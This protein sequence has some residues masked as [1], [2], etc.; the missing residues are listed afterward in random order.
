MSL[1]RRHRGGGAVESRATW[2]VP[3]WLTA[4]FGQTTAAGKP[5]SVENVMKSNAFAACRRVLVSEI[6]QLP[7]HAYRKSGST[8][9][10]VSPSPSI[11]STPAGGVSRRNWTAQ[12][13]DSLVRAGNAYCLIRRDSAGVVVGAE[14][15]AP[16]VVTWSHVDN[17]LRPFVGGVERDLFPNGDLLHIPASA[18]ITAGSPVA[19]SP[20]EAS[21]ES[22]GLGLAAESYVAEWFGS[23]GHPSSILFVD[24]EIT[25]QQAEQIK[26]RYV[27]STQGRRPAVFGAGIT[28]ESTQTPPDETMLNLARFVVE[29]ACRTTGVPPSMVYA[30]VSGQSVTYANVSD[31]DH[32]L[33]KHS[34]GV[35]LSDVE[36]YWSMLLPT[37][38]QYVQFNLDALLRSTPKERAEINQ[39]RLASKTITVNEVRALEDDPPFPDPMYDEPGVPG[40]LSTGVENAPT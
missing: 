35:W 24:R 17:V 18:F 13:V 34:L 1:I 25:A 19:V 27:E 11:V 31:S 3:G 5:V 15:V 7:V 32:Q 16:G 30:A 23:G 20:V 4:G 36:D 14:T 6:A 10:M 37:R 12:V 29:Q 8:R 26:D 38:G 39:I 9:R 22:L 33:L 28:R 40:G 2:P 21:A